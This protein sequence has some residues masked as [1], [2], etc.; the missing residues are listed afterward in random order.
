M[1]LSIILIVLVIQSV[2]YGVYSFISIDQYDA[3]LYNAAAT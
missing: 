3:G 1:T 2:L